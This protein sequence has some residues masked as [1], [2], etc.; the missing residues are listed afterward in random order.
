VI[1]NI[2][3]IGSLQS[4]SLTNGLRLI[5]V[6]HSEPAEIIGFPHVKLIDTLPLL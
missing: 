6:L 2:I 5:I 3:Y 1:V 4:I